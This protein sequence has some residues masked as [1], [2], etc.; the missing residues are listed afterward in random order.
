MSSSKRKYQVLSGTRHIYIVC[1]HYRSPLPRTTLLRE[2]RNGARA[3]AR[4]TIG[5]ATARPTKT[6]QGRPNTAAVPERRRDRRCARPSDC[7]RTIDK[8][9]SMCRPRDHVALTSV[10]IQPRKHVLTNIRYLSSRLVPH[11]ILQPRACPLLNIRY[12]MSRLVP[13]IIL[14]PRACPLFV[15]CMPGTAFALSLLARYRLVRVRKKTNSLPHKYRS[16][17]LVKEGIFG[18]MVTPMISGRG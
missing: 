14:E 4:L 18:V 7:E 3:T 12:Q 5:R 2:T 13:H 11:I 15:R 8:H 17:Y 10:I 9:S 1:S 6:D 16:Q